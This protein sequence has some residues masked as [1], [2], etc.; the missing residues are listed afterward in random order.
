MSPRQRLMWKA[1]EAAAS[2]SVP[3][4]GVEPLVND[5]GAT[6][7]IALNP[8]PA[9]SLHYVAD[10]VKASRHASAW[11]HLSR[12]TAFALQGDSVG[13]RPHFA[14]DGWAPVDAIAHVVGCSWVD[15]RH[16]LLTSRSENQPRFE[17][18]VKEGVDYMRLTP[19]LAPVRAPQVRAPR[20]RGSSG[21]G[22]LPLA[23][24]LLIGLVGC[25]DGGR[26][27]KVGSFA[28]ALS[29]PQGLKSVPLVG[30]ETEA[31]ASKAEI[32]FLDWMGEM[33]MQ[34]PLPVLAGCPLLFDRL[35]EQCG[36][37]L[38]EIG[39]SLGLFRHLL[40]GLQRKFPYLKGDLPRSW[41]LISRWESLE[42][43][44]HREPAPLS[45]VL[46]MASIAFLRGHLDF[47]MITLLMFHFIL[48]PCEAIRAVRNW[49]V[50]P[51]DTLSSGSV[52]YLRIPLAKSRWRGART[53]HASCRD[54]PF[55]AMLELR[56]ASLR[57]DCSLY[58]GNANSYRK[59]W[60]ALVLSL[61]LPP[62][63]YTPACLRAGG[64]CEAFSK[65]QDISNLMW[66]MRVTSMATLK[67]YLQEVVATS[68]LSDLEPSTRHLLRVAAKSFMFT[69]LRLVPKAYAAGA[70][71]SHSLFAQ[72]DSSDTER[73]IHRSPPAR[74]VGW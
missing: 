57:D 65:D 38:Y 34:S 35:I 58:E 29:A 11:Q 73:L 64:C 4:G 63:K 46:A 8:A 42:P 9:S 13:L 48:R 3:G 27:R 6:S 30:K 45:F 16:I 21:M 12:S 18:L 74:P 43:T 51:S 53:Q 44:V 49:L 54:S 50:L 37:S 52:A 7:S 67:H 61:Q 69:K 20:R 59:T 40:T 5:S 17:W 71:V 28:R 36:T 14:A 33:G 1:A 47:G 55:I 41:L 72:A 2:A 15:L 39:S 26:T 10:L 22:L 32:F 60:N 24:L 66:R 62:L 56:Y 31:L 25:V 23:A 68:S 19:S 70:S